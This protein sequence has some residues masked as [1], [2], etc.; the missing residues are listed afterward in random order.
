[1]VG[2]L[3]QKLPKMRPTWEMFKILEVEDVNDMSK[4]NISRRSRKCIGSLYK[5]PKS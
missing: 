5:D 4:A 3:E 2:I 1:M